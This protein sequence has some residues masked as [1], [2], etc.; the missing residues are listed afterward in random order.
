LP[1]NYD[2]AKVKRSLR[3]SI[4]DGSA[5]AAML[6]L[7]QNFVTPFALV[8]K[9]TTAQIGLLTSLSSLTTALS[10]LAAPVL[11]KMAGNR[12]SYILPMVFIH[13]LTWLPVLLIPFVFHTAQIWWL[14][15]FVTLGSIFGSISN[16]AWGSMMAD[17][18][19]V[20]LR[21]RY[22]GLRTRIS[23]IVTLVSSFIAGG[24]LELFSGNVLVGFAILIGGAFIARLL[25]FYF[26]SGMYEPPP[27][28]ELGDGE[29][30]F[31]MFKH[32]ASTNLG[33]FTLFVSL[34]YFATNIAS[35]FF[36]VYMLQDLKFSYT[37]YI[38]NVSFYAIAVLAVQTF[39]GRRADWA[40]NIRVIQIT[41]L[42]IPFVPLVW[43][44]SDNPYYLVM[45]QV[46]SGF[47]W[48]GFN[49]VS[50]NFVYDISET[51]SRTKYITFFNV[52][53]GVALCLGALAGGYMVPYLPEVRSNH[54]LTLFLISGVLRLVITLF[55]LR[56]ISEVRHVPRIDI[57]S[58]L[59][60][61]SGRT[62]KN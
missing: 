32:A 19:P 18:V 45:A 51:G 42:L 58:L 43:L 38:I 3:L 21:G 36:A 35:P 41:A 7:T 20:R 17:L 24:I 25:S 50:V 13:A 4:L 59:R 33:R 44:I 62:P 2:P 40:G 16:P 23:V 39:W 15:A 34:M 29:S 49:L 47:C 57:L 6:G 31:G 26:L 60:G 1:D 46:F 27:T 5:Q 48:G 12:K 54:F 55:F 11:T 52:M 28:R 30:L 53:C 61:R 10:Q 37:T 8:L 14:I 56:L 9:A 22:F